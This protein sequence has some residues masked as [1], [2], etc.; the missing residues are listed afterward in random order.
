MKQKEEAMT[1]YKALTRWQ[2][3]ETIDVE[4]L[5]GI[6]ETEKEA[7]EYACSHHDKVMLVDGVLVLFLKN[8]AP[9]EVP[10]EDLIIYKVKSKSEG[11]IMLEE[12]DYQ[13]LDADPKSLHRFGRIFR[14]FESLCYGANP[15]NTKQ[16]ARF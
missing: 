2:A 14:S 15:I 13:V 16:A 8:D 6:F 4:V 3:S 12:D 11:K 9:V 1:Q 7:M 5:Y 10:R